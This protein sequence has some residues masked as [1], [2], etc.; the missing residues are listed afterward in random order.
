MPEAPRVFIDTSVWISGLISPN[1]P[2]GRLLDAYVAGAIIPVVSPALLAEIRDVSRRPRVRRR[3]R[4]SQEA[5]EAFLDRLSR[6]GLPVQPSGEFR[7]CR[8]P[9]DDIHL[10][11]AI[12]GQ[13]QY[14]VSRDD[15]MK[16]DRDLMT[17]MRE[18]G[19]QVLTVVQLLRLLESPTV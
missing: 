1:G 16:R 17:R 12:L 5:V 6:T 11:T 13:A 19:V 2:P 18:Q 7:A 15:D 9:R 3:I 14:V 4:F 10:E 8:D